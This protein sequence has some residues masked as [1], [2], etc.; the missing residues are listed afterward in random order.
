M[1]AEFVAV[2]F[3]CFVVLRLLNAISTSA[4]TPGCPCLGTAT[5]GFVVTATAAA[6][7]SF[8]SAAKHVTRCYRFRPGNLVAIVNNSP[9]IPEPRQ[10]RPVLLQF[11][12]TLL[13]S[14]ASIKAMDKCR[15]PINDYVEDDFSATSRTKLT[16]I[17]QH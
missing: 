13:L 8:D 12:Q 14:A 1:S 2:L 9:N 3:G 17:L 5:G 15:L 4:V 6:A 10:A 16:K 11:F 7:V